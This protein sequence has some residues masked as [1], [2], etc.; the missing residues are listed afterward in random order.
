MNLKKQTFLRDIEK[1]LA[2]ENVAVFAGA[3][4]SAGVGFVDWAELLRPIADELGLDIDK[5][6]DLVALAQFHCNDNAN[7]RSQLNQRLIEEFS[8]KSTE[9]ENHRIFCRLPI[10]TYW[11]TNYD[12]VIETAL[13]RS[14]KLRM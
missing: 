13:E 5:E 11:T 7:N 4:M 8:Q 6:S 1:E 2:E 12:K 10:R 14:G 3:G 9:T